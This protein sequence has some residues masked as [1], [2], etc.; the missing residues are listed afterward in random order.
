MSLLYEYGTIKAM[1][2]RNRL[3]A[4]RNRL[5]G[6]LFFLESLNPDKWTELDQSF[7]YNYNFI[8]DQHRS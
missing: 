6:A 4:R 1:Y 7:G 5:T 3:R 8:P 2:G